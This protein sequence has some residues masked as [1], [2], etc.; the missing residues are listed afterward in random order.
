[1]PLT[2]DDF[3]SMHKTCESVIESIELMNN[4]TQGIPSM[5]DAQLEGLRQNVTALAVIQRDLIKSVL[6]G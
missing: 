3:I 4:A 2:P 6:E 5:V 1:M